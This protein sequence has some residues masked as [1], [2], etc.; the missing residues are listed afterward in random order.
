MGFPKLLG[1]LLIAYN[2]VV[3]KLIRRQCSSNPWTFFI[4]HQT[5][6]DTISKLLTNCYTANLLTATWH[7]IWHFSLVWCVRAFSALMLLVGCQEGHPA[8][9][10]TEWWGA[11]VVICLEPGAYLHMVQLMMP[12]PLTVSCFSKI[13]IGFTFVVLAH[14]GSPRQQQQRPFNGLWSGTTRVGRY[15]KELSPTHT[16]PNHRASFIIFLHLQWSMASSLFNLPA[17]Q[18]S[19]TTSFQVFFGLPLGLEP[20]TSCSI[21][22]FTQSSS[23]FRNTWPYQRS[24]FCCNTNAMSSTPSLSLSSLRW[25]K[26]SKKR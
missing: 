10:K 7:F 1:P 3:M 5:T 25:E 11:G 18:S 14:L 21:H 9:K 23:S 8:C 2:T 15:Q 24:L 17:W 4:Q 12:L 26:L 13:Q 22:F 19:R 6:P 16:Y 20:S